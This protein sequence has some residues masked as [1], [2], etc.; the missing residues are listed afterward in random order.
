MRLRMVNGLFTLTK[1]SNTRQIQSDII[2]HAE[3]YATYV[4]TQAQYLEMLAL[5]IISK[6]IHVSSW[7]EP[8]RAMI[9]DLMVCHG[10]QTMHCRTHHYMHVCCSMS[11]VSKLDSL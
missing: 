5:G 4:Y 9:A 8:E 6:M 11:M 2:I 10:T 3:L 1:F 7:G